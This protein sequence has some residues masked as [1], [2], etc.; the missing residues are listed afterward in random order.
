SKQPE[1]KHAAVAIEPVALPWQLVAMA[2]LPAGKALVVREAVAALARDFA[3]FS[4]VPFGD[5]GSGDDGSADRQV[6]VLLRMASAKAPEA[7]RIAPLIAQLEGWFGVQA[8]D[9]LRYDDAAR[10]Q[11]R[12]MRVAGTG[13]GEGERL[14]A[15]L[16]VGQ[17]ASQAWV[18]PLLQERQPVQ[19]LGTRLLSPSAQPPGDVVSRGKQVCTCFNVS[20]PQIMAFLP[21]CSGTEGER[22]GQLQ[23]AL[24]C[25]TNCGSCVPALR[26]LIR[27]TPM[28]IEAL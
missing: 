15:F 11:H 24:K 10:H 25:G 9:T 22:L 17:V 20:E 16:M 27:E 13:E 21:Q 3:F 5:E 8:S 2:W 14:Q 12:A 26:K 1:L 28:A 4:C 19:A 7:E 23:G 6:G 18:R